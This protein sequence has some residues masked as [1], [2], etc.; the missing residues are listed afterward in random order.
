MPNTEMRENWKS[1]PWTGFIPFN[2]FMLWILMSTLVIL[3]TALVPPPAAGQPADIYHDIVIATKDG[4]QGGTTSRAEA[5][6]IVY[7]ALYVNQGD[8]SC[9]GRGPCFTSIQ[10]A[11]ESQE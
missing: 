8:D 10:A 9:G 3:S 11:L 7:K 6:V 5:T 1:R 4:G 2:G